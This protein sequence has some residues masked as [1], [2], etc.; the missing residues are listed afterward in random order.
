MQGRFPCVWQRRI[1]VCAIFNQK[2]A[3]PPVS[4]EDRVSETE[5][6]PKWLKRF[7]V[8]QQKPDGADVTVERT[9]LDD[10]A[11]GSRVVACCYIVMDQVR[12]SGCDPIKHRVP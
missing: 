5:V 12:A 11:R 2:L 6:W 4:K 1:H 3:E 7:A 8:S 9:R 10:F